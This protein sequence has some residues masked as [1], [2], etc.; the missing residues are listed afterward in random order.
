M[1]AKIKKLFLILTPLFVSIVILFWGFLFETKFNLL[2]LEYEPA[3]TSM[4]AIGGIAALIMTFFL[5]LRK[6][7]NYT[8]EFFILALGFASMGILDIAHAVSS[9]GHGF[10]LLRSVSSLIGSIFMALVWFPQ[11]ISGDNKNYK[12]LF[13]T[14]VA[15]SLML[16]I[17]PWASRDILPPMMI[18]GQFTSAAVFI[19]V[20]S[21]IFFLVSA[22]KLFQ[23][24]FSSGQREFYLL[25]FVAVLFA[26]AGFLF[27]VS[28]AWHSTWWLWHLVRVV[29]YFILM[30]ILIKSYELKS[31]SLI[32]LLIQKGRLQD[33]LAASE[34]KHR[35]IFESATDAFFII[36]FSGK[37]VEVNPSTC[38]LYGY[39]RQE[40]IGKNTLELI[41]PSSHYLFEEFIDSLQKK[42][43]F[44]G[45]T[46]DVRK[47]GTTFNTEVIGS[48]IQYNNE[49]H[50]LAIIRDVSQR[51]RIEKAL[52]E[53][54]RR[55]RTLFSNDPDAIFL[56]EAETGII[57]DVNP[58]AEK[59]TNKKRDEIIGMHQAL[60]HPEDIRNELREKFQ[61]GVAAKS[62]IVNSEVITSDYKRIPVEILA[63][64]V[65]LDDKT[66]FMGLFRDVSERKEAEEKLKDALTFN[67]TVI[68]SST[69]GKAVYREDG[70][71]I[72][73]NLR[74]AEL[75][76][77]EVDQLLDQNYRELESWLENGLKEEADKI[78]ESGGTCRK[79]IQVNLN[80]NKKMWLECHFSRFFQKNQPHLLMIYIDITEKIESSNILKK[81][82]LRLK[83][84]NKE[85]EQF[86]YVASHDLQEPLRMVSSYTQLLE[87][88]YKDK[89]DKDAGE[90]INYAVDGAKR[91][92]VLI[93]DLLHY[94]RV[95]TRAGK[96]EKVN[97]D[98]LCESVLRE[99]HYKI[100]ENRAIITKNSLPEITADEN[101]IKIVFSNII[102]N[103]LK[104]K[105]SEN[106]RIQIEF[107]EGENDYLFSIK[108]N[109]MGIDSRYQ[110]K[111]FTIFSRLHTKEKFEGTGM[112]LA[113]CKRIVERHGG[114]IWVESEPGKGSTFH[115]TIK[116]S[117]E[118][119]SY[120]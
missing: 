98:L 13:W 60:L 30:A 106:P 29:S 108:D 51:K 111:I 53:N 35:A 83:N 34:E 107:D 18:G 75:F 104:Y 64:V 50:M 90:F 28:D 80:S 19:N 91:M 42:G 23:L 5:L 46:I 89:L 58:A 102:D 74:A 16:S 110:E 77:T 15:L 97:T 40:L 66:Y 71:C 54:E 96:F 37:V 93:N 109:G 100:E 9:I 6:G 7:E 88:R 115:F 41:H 4:E 72:L 31:Q 94:S 92:K 78:L 20:S 118:E 84:A 105:N 11:I 79:E 52:I 8:R 69:L 25:A 39:P 65:D 45:E 24:F 87:K 120:E 101:Q 43:S 103:A 27:P 61:Q 56:A 59:L 99:M 17:L 117:L 32:K 114:N 2:Y 119:F 44:T 14:T 95:T 86:A 67:E 36:D 63:A 33:E 22:A 26:L 21:G 73:A 1:T 62:T 12:I 70:Q 68:N 76:E 38:K 112:G 10:V 81:A 113:L 55:F 47:D 48:V 49:K 3:H 116:K 82:N 57:V 85:L